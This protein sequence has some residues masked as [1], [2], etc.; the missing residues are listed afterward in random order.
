[1]NYLL[2]DD[3]QRVHLL[4]LAATRPIADF[5]IGILTLREKWNLA[6]G[7]ICSILTESYLQSKYPAHW[8]KENFLINGRLFPS[9]EFLQLIESLEPEQKLVQGDTILAVRTSQQYI[10][11]FET[12]QE[13]KLNEVE[14]AI[15]LPQFKN[16]WDIFQM[17][18]SWIEFDFKNLT[19]NR[20]S[21]PIPP[22]IQTISPEN[23]FIEEGATLHFSTLNASSGPI[24]IGKNSEVMEG[25]LIR[26][27]FALLHH[28][29]TKLGTKI[30]GPTTIGPHSKV[31]GELNN[32]V[33]F[34]YSNKAHD[35]FLGNAVLGEW[36]N[37]GADSNNSNLK[38]NYADV[39][40][41][42]Y[43]TENL[44]SS[45][46]Q[47][48]GLIM[49]DHSKC[50]I[51]TMFNTGTVVGVNANI[52]GAGFPP[53]FVPDFSW[54]GADGYKNYT[55]RVALHVAKLVMQRRAIEL[56]KA[57]VEILTH[58]YENTQHLRS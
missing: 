33:V 50:A 44:I 49:G 16:L 10:E 47:F 31:G 25:S 23:I 27:P 56:S 29:A 39:K 46:L 1:M 34:G 52:F 20:Q 4:P 13:L 14:T 58:I 35:G 30:Y 42:S 11:S 12:L 28:S 54:G 7:S 51:N 36:C 53:T 22:S 43:A 48:C 8:G 24:Y 9:P 2:F 26:G 17:N 41:W 40:I 37:I 55:L 32:V 38:N 57:D 45:G 21:A 5:R 19:K 18:G 6:L 3:P 15:A